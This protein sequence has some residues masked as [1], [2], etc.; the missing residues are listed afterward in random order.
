[1]IAP[2]IR[3]AFLLALIVLVLHLI[4]IKLY[5]Y[6]TVW[7]FDIL[8]HTLGGV[9]I[10]L[11]AELVLRRYGFRTTTLN[12]LAIV[13]VIGIGWEVFEFM[14]GISVTTPGTY[15]QDTL[16]DLVCDLIGGYLGILFIR[17]KRLT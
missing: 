3:R 9:L 6:W 17:N 12:I 15:A 1:M 14:K 8:T 7:W 16:L 13:F 5:L 11:L 4:G 2:D 10:A